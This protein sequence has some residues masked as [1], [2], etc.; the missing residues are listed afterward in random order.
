[1]FPDL[2]G[3]FW[4]AIFGLLCIPLAGYEIVRF[5]LWLVGH[6]HWI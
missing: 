6:L 5:V 2:R 3:L 4:L 1:M